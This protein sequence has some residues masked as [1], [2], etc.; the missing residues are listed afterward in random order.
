MPKRKTHEQFEKELIAKRGN[1]YTLLEKYQKWDTKM[2]VKHNVCGYEWKVT[3]ANLLAGQSKCPNCSKKIRLNTKTFQE[4][5]H[6]VLDKTYTVIGEYI[7]DGSHV[8]ILHETCGYVWNAVPNWIFCSHVK[9]PRCQNRENYT[10]E[11]FNRKLMEMTDD[12]YELL[13]E[14]INNRYLTT[15]RHNTCGHI[16]EEAPN[17]IMFGSSPCPECYESG[18]K[19]ERKIA[20][21]LNKNEIKFKE[22]YTFD[23]CKYINSLRFDFSIEKV[24]Q[25]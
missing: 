18:S 16:F 2:L 3:P 25:H 5:I 8:E 14:Y 12:E 11:E 6:R 9:C 13:G 21:Y 10:T 23:D 17:K 7:N 24:N 22:Q 20:N 15:F 4:K 19:G 1:E